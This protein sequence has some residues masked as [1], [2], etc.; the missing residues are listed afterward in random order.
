MHLPSAIV[1]GACPLADAQIP[2]CPNC[3]RLEARVAELEALVSKL[4]DRIDALE[5]RNASLEGEIARLRRNSSNSHKPPSSDIVKPRPP[6][7]TR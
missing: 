2:E 4:L 7:G 1:Y 3:R 5:V 6:A